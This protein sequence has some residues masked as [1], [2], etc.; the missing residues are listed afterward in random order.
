MLRHPLPALAAFV[1]LLPLPAL[2]D[3]LTAEAIAEKAFE[4]EFM[5]LSTGVAQVNMTLVNKRGKKRERR[6]S[7]KTAKV[8]GLRH[9]LIRFL[10]PADVQGTSFLL[11]EQKDADDDQYLYLPAL[12]RTR[13]IAGSQKSGS[14]MGSDFSYADMESR[15]V[16]DST[17]KR[18]ADEKIGP[19][20]CYHVEAT[21]KKPDDEDYART[22][23]WIHKQTS[24]PLRIRFFGKKGG[25]LAKTLFVE[26][27][28]K[29][30]GRW[31]VTKARMKNE[32]KGSSTLIVME[33][34]DLKADVPAS[35]LT[36]EAL[37][38][39]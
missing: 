23:H 15:D 21:P 13:R 35:E 27:F 14:F 1:G 28:K 37:S 38:G 11:I 29:I 16:A 6:I 33:S 34:I 4:Q 31:L 17:W 20:D 19:A 18:H 7:S 36:V 22:E 8:D 39:G 25:K 24:L 32:K 26:E 5:A 9:T 10:S 3:D 2:A 12:K 30:D